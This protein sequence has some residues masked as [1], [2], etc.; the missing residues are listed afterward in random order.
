MEDSAVEVERPSPPPDSALALRQSTAGAVK[1]LQANGM[2]P[3]IIEDSESDEDAIIN[4]K[5]DVEDNTNN[6]Q[7]LDA[8][9]NPKEEQKNQQDEE[10]EE[11]EEDDDDDDDVA[12]PPPEGIYD[13][14]EFEDLNVGAEIKELFSDILRYTPQAIDLETRFKPFIPEFIPAVGDIDAFIKVPRPDAAS[15]KV[16]LSVLDEPAARQSDPSVLDLQL[17]AI[18][19]RSSGKQ[20]VV[21]KVDSNTEKSA[22]SIDKWIKDISDLHRSKPPP[23]VHYS[24]PMPDIDSLMQEWPGPIEEI[25]HETGMPTADYDCDTASYVDIIC[26]LLDIPVHKSRIQSLH[27]FFSLYSAFKHSAHFNQFNQERN[28]NNNLDDS[29]QLML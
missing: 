13:P 1:R 2:K 28:N 5:E 19:K 21:K 12:A 10:D 25:L 24:K 8:M 18:S 4:A 27:V 9:K 15:E 7:V 11:D 29:Q 6:E 22:K 17:R 3:T 16:G 14:G 20:A 23:S 26:A